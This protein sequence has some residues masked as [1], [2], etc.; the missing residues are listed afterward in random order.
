MYR[1]V[2]GKKRTNTQITTLRKPDGSQTSERKETLRLMLEYFT[3]EDKDLDDKNHYK[4]IRELTDRQPKTPDDREFTR[5]D[6][7]WVI[8]GLEK[9]MPQRRPNNGGNI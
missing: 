2:S 6:L 9:K 8:E 5:E 7:G 3:P 1:L 4:Q